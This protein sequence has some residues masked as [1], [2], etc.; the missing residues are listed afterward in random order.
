MLVLTNALT[1][2]HTPH[3]TMSNNERAPTAPN[4]RQ[5][6]WLLGTLAT[7]VVLATG[8]QNFFAI[9]QRVQQLEVDKKAMAEA[10]TR[11]QDAVSARLSAIESKMAAS[12]EWQ[13]QMLVSVGRISGTMDTM[14]TM[15]TGLN[16]RLVRNEE[17]IETVRGVMGAELNRLRETQALLHEGVKVKAP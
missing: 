14:S 15:V 3:P 10:A 8:A 11:Q 9:P 16:D 6:T 2:P 4:A 1:Q 7:I 5:W 13:Q 12:S 17:R